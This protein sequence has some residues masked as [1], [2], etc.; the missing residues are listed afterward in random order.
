MMITP[1][2]QP[3]LNTYKLAQLAELRAT[4]ALSET[5]FQT[6]KQSLLHG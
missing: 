2:R 6:A 4:G 5:E 3:Q 1:R